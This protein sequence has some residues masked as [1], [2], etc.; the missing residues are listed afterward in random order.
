MCSPRRATARSSSTIL[1]ALKHMRSAAEVLD[2]HLK[3]RE[4]GD[5]DGDVEQNYAP[6]VVLLCEHGVMRRREAIRQSAEALAAQL[7]GASFVYPVK[8]VDGEYALLL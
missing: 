8:E 2:D 6:D 7:P 1:T 4:A 3:R 5:L